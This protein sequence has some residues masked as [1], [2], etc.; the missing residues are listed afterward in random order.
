MITATASNASIAAA[1]IS[2][3]SVERKKTNVLLGH[4]SVVPQERK[5]P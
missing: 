2:W 1:I 5:S 3:A 4:A